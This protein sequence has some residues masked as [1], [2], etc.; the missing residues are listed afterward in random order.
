M[1]KQ[2]PAPLPAPCPYPG[3]QGISKPPTWLCTLPSIQ[4]PCPSH[5][6]CSSCRTEA[7]ALRS[8][9]PAGRPRAA[10]PSPTVWWERTDASTA[11]T[12]RPPGSRPTSPSRWPSRQAGSSAEPRTLWAPRA[13]PSDYCRQV[14]GRQGRGQWTALGRGKP[15][16]PV[17]CLTGELPEGPAMVLAG[18]LASITAVTSGMLG[19]TMWTR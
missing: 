19:W 5:R 11:S 17:I 10:P 8:G 9:C 16:P 18:S 3:Q 12:H 6:L 13:V 7:R 4:S 1:Q 14:R 2:H 15:Q